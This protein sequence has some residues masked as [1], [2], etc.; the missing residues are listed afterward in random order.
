M[1]DLSDL[2]SIHSEVQDI[3]KN[4]KKTFSAQD[5]YFKENNINT[6]ADHLVIARVIQD[7]GRDNILCSDP[8]VWFWDECGLW[9]LAGKSAKTRCSAIEMQGER[10]TDGLVRSVAEVLKAEIYQPEHE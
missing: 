2:G 10:V 9:K 1:K 8:H 3:I 4:R 6:E 5:Q 7:I